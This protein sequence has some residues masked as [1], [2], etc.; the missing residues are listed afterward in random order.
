MNIERLDFT[1]NFPIFQ[2]ATAILRI[3]VAICIQL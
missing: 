2:L 1:V 3:F